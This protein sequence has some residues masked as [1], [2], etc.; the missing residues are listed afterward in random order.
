MDKVEYLK[1]MILSGVN[2]LHNN[3]PHIDKLNVFPVP[4]GDTGTNMNLTAT[5]GYRDIKDKKFQTIGEELSVFARGL[6]MGAR[7]N[8]GVIFSQIVKGFS[9]GMK[10]ATLLNPG[11]WKQ[12]LIKASEIAYQAVMKPVEG[13]IL[14]VIRETAEQANGLADDLDDK[15]FWT[16][17]CQFANTSLDN[18]PNLL[19]QLKDV[20]VVDSGG[21]GLVKFFEGMSYYVQNSKIV[22]ELQKLEVNDGGNLDIDLEDVE[23][24]YCT[25]TI[26][27]LSSNYVNKLKVNTIRDQLQLYGNTSMVVIIDDDIL[28]V[29]THALNPGQ[30]L[31]FLQQYGDFRTVKVENMTLQSDYQVKGGNP[32]AK[33]GWS[34]SSTV[35]KERNLVNQTA[36]IA[37]VQSEEQKDYFEKEL[38]ID[39]A[40]NAGDKMNPST[41]DFLKAIRDV[42]A[43]NVFIL[44]NNSNVIL[45][46]RQA[47]KEEKK[48][49][50]LVIPTKTI[51]QGVSSALSFE[52]GGNT[53]A[54]VKNLTKAVKNVISFSIAQAAKD[55]VSD[56]VDVKKGQQMAIVDNKIIE[57]QPS[58]RAVFEKSLSKYITNKVEILTIF[59]G[60]DADTSNVN[61]LRKMLDEDYN[62]E[63]EIVEGGQKIYTFIIG[64]E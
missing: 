10:D 27:D 48:S 16:Q 52:P 60:Q 44:P 47:E 25:E 63:Y 46:A 15:E 39:L 34:E 22:A 14:T 23:F 42:D 31:T 40:I 36:T 33:K 59:V 43:K 38:G 37:V 62:I 17:I 45:A 7:G 1:E 49:K 61:D 50:V 35:L 64:I 58:I 24:G 55:S 3:Y 53:S 56:G 57:T 41:N 5:N 18:T 19:Q 8:S 54:N 26:V 6:I 51:P 4:D 9:V 20:G 28:K 11:E 13:T 32:N 21:Y 12:G 29:H 30:V 2:N